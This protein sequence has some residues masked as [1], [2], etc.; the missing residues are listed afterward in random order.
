MRNAHKTS[1]TII[2]ET[3]EEVDLAFILVK[4]KKKKETLQSNLEIKT[5]NKNIVV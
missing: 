1:R 3:V 2:L 4:K 5:V